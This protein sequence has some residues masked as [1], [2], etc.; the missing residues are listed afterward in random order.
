MAGSRSKK[1]GGKYDNPNAKDD[2]G[3]GILN[4]GVGLFQ[5]KK[6]QMEDAAAGKQPKQIDS[7][8]AKSRPNQTKDKD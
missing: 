5:K 3:T 7:N 6:Q 1:S 2:T 4:I 8:P